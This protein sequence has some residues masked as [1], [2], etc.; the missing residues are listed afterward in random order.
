[1]ISVIMPVWNGARFMDRATG[2]AV[3]QTSP[4]WELLIVDDGSTDDS[5]AKAER[6]RDLVN[7]HFGEEK[8]RTFSTEI[9]NSV[10]QVGRNMSAQKARYNIF[11]YLD[12]D[13]LFFPRRIESLIPLFDQYEMVFAPYEILERGRVTLWNLQALWQR[14]SY[15]CSSEGDREPPFE[16]WAR[17]SLQQHILSVPLGVANRRK[18]YEKVGGVSTRNFSWVRRSPLALD[19]RSRSE[20]RLLPYYCGTLLRST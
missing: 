11:A 8:I 15:V 3:A 18:I 19:G 1:M 20:N 5:L 12:M 13:D 9:A 17:S 10:H 14:S 6:W 16:A 7:S 2:S 4:E